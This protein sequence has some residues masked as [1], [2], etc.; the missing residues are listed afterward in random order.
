MWQPYCFL[1]KFC[2]LCLHKP[3][4]DERTLTAPLAIGLPDELEGPMGRTPQGDF[5][6]PETLLMSDQTFQSTYIHHAVP[7][8]QGGGYAYIWHPAIGEAFTYQLTAVYE[9][10]ESDFALTPTG[11]S[12]L[13][14][15]VTG[16][17]E[18]PSN[19]LIKVLS[20]YNMKGQR[21]E[22]NDISEL[23]IG[24]YIIQGLTE[25]GRLVCE[26]KHSY[27]TSRTNRTQ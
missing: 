13:T 15:E 11:D 9:Q 24:I 25:D 8:G 26:K 12:F 6:S 10:C 2:Y 19:S 17:E 1:G 16:L 22:A 18:Q 20:I 4:Y 27:F 21:V 5:I 14:I 7:D 23:P 3:I